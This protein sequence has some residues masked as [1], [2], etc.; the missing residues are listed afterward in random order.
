MIKRILT[1]VTHKIYNL[2]VL[3]LMPHSRCNCRCVMCD[4]WK[5]NAEKRELSA[6]D[7]QKHIG[8]FKKLG[9][10]RVALSGG[11]ALMHSNLWLLC[12]A[13]KDIGA[14]ISLLSTGVTLKSHANDVV[15][16]CDDV[17]VSLDGSPAVHNQIRNIPNAFEKLAE[18][19]KALKDLNPS[20]KVTGRCVIQRSN[21][22]DFEEILTT[23]LQLGLDQISFLPADV[24]STA[25]NRPERWE[26][27]KV[28]QVALEP[29]EVDELESIIKTSFINFRKLYRS[30]FI[31]ESPEKMLRIPQYYRAI[32]GKSEFPKQWCNA[33]WVSAVVESNGDVM[34]CFFHKPYGN[35]YAND[36]LA[37]VNS[38]MAIHFRRN[39]DIQQNEICRKCVCSLYLP[40]YHAD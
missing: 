15:K 37:I 8:A 20:F 23:A 35:I 3:V 38:P 12:A 18:G 28:H 10:K 24:S 4:I 31:A 30:R 25:F 27:E 29:D 1:S 33:P 2:P 6:E 19:V 9:V 21:F 11:E 17:I 14:K 40:F 5:A 32:L 22:R 26:R 13:L 7:I 39:L 36:F 16:Y 34:P